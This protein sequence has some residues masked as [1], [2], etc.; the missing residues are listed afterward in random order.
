MAYSSACF[1]VNTQNLLLEKVRPK[2]GSGRGRRRKRVAGW[3]GGW[4]GHLRVRTRGRSGQG[5]FFTPWVP[6]L[7]LPQRRGGQ[8]IHPSTHSPIHP[9]THSRIHSF[10]HSDTVWAIGYTGSPVSVHSELPAGQL[11]T[12]G[13]LSTRTFGCVQR[14]EAV[15]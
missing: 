10:T 7:F 12:R 6:H 8:S 13:E 11:T 9:F 15:E 1:I 14:W 3:R 2:A 5:S 4:W